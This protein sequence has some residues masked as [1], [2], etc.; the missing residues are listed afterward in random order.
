MHEASLVDALFDQIDTIRAA[1]PGPPPPAALRTVRVRLGAQAG[2]D[3]ELF[4][5]AFEVLRQG[6]GYAA[7][8]L[9]LER[10]PAEWRCVA[11]DAVIETEN[12]QA[13][14]CP[15]C[16]AGARLV[17]GAEI[18]LERIE[19]ALPSEKGDDHV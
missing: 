15:A 10:E 5:I 14:R 4:T 9:T 1:Q 16:C 18:V 19:L 11:C 12:G 7:A 3:A 8:A 13:L 17:R 6:R 2:V